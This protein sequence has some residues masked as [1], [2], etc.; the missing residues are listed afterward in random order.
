MLSEFRALFKGGAG[1]RILLL[2]SLYD[3]TQAISQGPVPNNAKGGVMSQPTKLTLRQVAVFAKTSKSTVSRYLTHDPRISDS[4]RARIAKVIDEKGFAPNMMA[5]GLAGGRTG[6]FGIVGGMITSGFAADVLNGVN[7]YL[8]PRNLH[9]L[10]TTAHEPNDFPAVISRLSRSRMIDGLLLI[11]PPVSLFETP[12]PDLPTVLCATRDE[13]PGGL[14]SGVNSLFGDNEGGF[15]AVLDKLVAT[16]HRR[17]LH[18][19][20][21]RTNFDAIARCKTFR[22]FMRQHK[23]CRGFVKQSGFGEMDGWESITDYFSSKGHVVPDAIV[24]FN[25]ANAMGVLRALKTKGIVNGVDITVTGC[26]DDP[27]AAG[28]GLSTIRFP[29]YEMGANAAEILKG[30]IDRIVE[31]KPLHQKMPVQLVWRLAK[32]GN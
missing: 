31:A 27:F 23:D 14:W 29:N 21:P 2:K 13:K 30:L 9:M 8:A 19:S 17:F 28:L 18:L 4:V 26:D 10:F 7:S 6:L 12:S 5:R 20:G 1:S 11:A 22:S 3:D 25:D 16:G 15:L 32:A 24:C